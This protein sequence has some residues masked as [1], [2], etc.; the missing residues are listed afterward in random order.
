MGG[1]DKLQLSVHLQLLL[2]AFQKLCIC[3]KYQ[4]SCL[5]K[6]PVQNHQE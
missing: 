3:L 2:T 1:N 5:T 4:V 6:A